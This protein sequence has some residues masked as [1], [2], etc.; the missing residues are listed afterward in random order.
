MLWSWI[1]TKLIRQY[2]DVLLV[3]PKEKENIESNLKFKM[4]IAKHEETKFF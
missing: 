3:L 1:D 4:T 2:V